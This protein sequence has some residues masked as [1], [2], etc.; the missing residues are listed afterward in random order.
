[1]AWSVDGNESRWNEN[2]LDLDVDVTGL[3]NVMEKQVA[4]SPQD[5]KS[6]PA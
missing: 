3:A 4:L 6:S 2:W 1:M 5:N